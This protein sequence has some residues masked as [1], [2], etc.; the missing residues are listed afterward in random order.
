MS[1][2]G[3][4][5]VCN[6]NIVYGNLKSENSQE[7]DQKVSTKLYVL[8][9]GFRTRD[10]CAKRGKSRARAGMQIAEGEGYRWREEERGINRQKRMG[11]GSESC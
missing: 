5:L 9:F 11:M 10:G 2:R 8:E 7:Y 6:V 3:L 4:K 1:N